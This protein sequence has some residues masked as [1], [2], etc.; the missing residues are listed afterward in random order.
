MDWITLWK[1]L[2]YGNNFVSSGHT[3]KEYSSFKQMPKDPLI[4][5]HL[6]EKQNDKL[7][8]KCIKKKWV[9]DQNNKNLPI[10]SEKST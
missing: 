1:P 6:L 5:M 2:E 10:G 3:A 9:Y 8:R 4:K 7:V